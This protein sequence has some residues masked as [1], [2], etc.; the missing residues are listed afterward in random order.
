MAFGMSD[1]LSLIPKSLVKD[2]ALDIQGFLSDMGIY[3]EED[4]TYDELTQL[5]M[6]AES[7]NLPPLPGSNFDSMG[8]ISIE[9]KNLFAGNNAIKT[10]AL[11]QEAIVDEIANSKAAK[12][13]SAAGQILEL[14]PEMAFG[15]PGDEEWEHIIF[16]YADQFDTTPNELIEEL[17]AMLSDSGYGLD[18]EGTLEEDRNARDLENARK[19]NKEGTDLWDKHFG[20]DAIK[21]RFED[22]GDKDPF[23]LDIDRRPDPISGEPGYPDMKN[24]AFVP[25][26]P[27]F[28]GPTDVPDEERPESTELLPLPIGPLP[29]PPPL[30]IGPLPPPPPLP[31]KPGDDDDD[32]PPPPPTNGETVPPPQTQTPPEGDDPGGDD[33]V[34][35]LDPPAPP[36]GAMPGSGSKDDEPVPHSHDTGPMAGKSHTHPLDLHPHGTEGNAS[37]RKYANSSNFHRLVAESLGLSDKQS[38]LSQYAGGVNFGNMSTVLGQMGQSTS[39]ILKTQYDIVSRK[40]LGRTANPTLKERIEDNFEYIVGLWVHT[41]LVPHT[42][43]VNAIKM[44]YRN[45]RADL[46]KDDIKGWNDSFGKE[47]EEIN[48]LEMDAKD[49]WVFTDGLY[50]KGDQILYGDTS[51]DPNRPQ[52]EKSWSAI[53]GAEQMADSDEG[54]GFLG[55]TDLVALIKTAPFLLI[56]SAALVKG[57]INN[58]GIQGKLR[59]KEWELKKENY[60]QDQA[61]KDPKDF[62]T[63]LEWLPKQKG[64]ESTYTPDTPGK[65]FPHSHSDHG[66]TYRHSHPGG[67]TSHSHATTQTLSTQNQ[68]QTPP[69]GSAAQVIDVPGGGRET[70]ILGEG[71]K[72]TKITPYS[73]TA[74][75]QNVNSDNVAAVLQNETAKADALEKKRIEQSGENVGLGAP[76][77][78]VPLSLQEEMR[79]KVAEANRQREEYFRLYGGN[80]NQLR[81]NAMQAKAE[82]DAV[83]AAQQ[84]RWAQPGI[85]DQT[86]HEW[87]FNTGLTMD[88]RAMAALSGANSPLTP[89]DALRSLQL[90]G[91]A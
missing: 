11:N 2:Q 34:V 21:K 79:R 48:N 27:I 56:D 4:M 41:Q 39:A 31:V 10:I 43:K 65:D 60:Q 71:E 49:F 77:T 14:F 53:V 54:G 86:V 3:D 50:S 25:P 28:P 89:E 82:A 16:P 69:V 70:T 68:T 64:F 83:A 30:P 15:D 75:T 74:Q 17:R 61:F 13:K 72:E 23:A 26:P 80:E 63:F 44:K 22:S 55:N 18:D 42:E 40:W 6:A 90:R 45:Q 24:P 8:D 46:D 88:P 85:G 78:N 73:H 87:I 91:L 52:V 37:D 35:P 29:P 7:G 5:A 58:V 32:G 1:I 33:P 47:E 19:N 84:A 62:E 20:K 9:E 66:M 38:K 76:A 67:T 57:N 81:A 12:T 51:K 59:R 36:V